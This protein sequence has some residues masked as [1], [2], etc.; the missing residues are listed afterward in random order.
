MKKQQQTSSTVL[1]NY[2]PQTTKGD[3][4]AFPRFWVDEF[5]TTQLPGS[6]WKFTLHLWRWL[7][8]PREDGSGY[9]TGIALDDF[10]V[11]TAAAV[12]WT[13]AYA[14][15]GFVVVKLGKWKGDATEFTYRQAA[16]PQEWRCFLRALD[17]ATGLFKN[18]RGQNNAGGWKVCV[19]A[20]VDEERVAAGLPP[21]NTK[22]L[23]TALLLTDAI[24]RPIAT[25]LDDGS[26]AGLNYPSTPRRKPTEEE[27]AWGPAFD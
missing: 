26:I 24:G 16:T 2:N 17:Y 6:F 1:V 15:S 23:E 18:A 20:R 25:K 4:V 11:R 21:V 7:S 12:Q 13:A 8:I 5:F 10:P 22:W 14:V 27:L 19:A 3:Y 9:H